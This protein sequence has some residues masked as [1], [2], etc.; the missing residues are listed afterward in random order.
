M[1]TSRHRKLVP[2]TKNKTLL[3]QRSRHQNKKLEPIFYL[4]QYGALGFLER[5]ATNFEREFN[6]ICAPCISPWAYETINRWNAKAIGSN[7]GIA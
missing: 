1:A 2:T 4:R 7:C 6:F 3:P 5:E